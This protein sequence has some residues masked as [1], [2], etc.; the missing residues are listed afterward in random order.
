MVKSK[1]VEG[2]RMK[3][4]TIIK[5]LSGCIFVAVLLLAMVLKYNYDHRQVLITMASEEIDNSEGILAIRTENSNSPGTYVTSNYKDL[6]YSTH[7]FDAN[8]SY[9]VRGGTVV[10]DKTNPS[11]PV[12]KV[13]ARGNDKCFAYFS[14]LSRAPLGMR[15][16]LDNGGEATILAKNPPDFSTPVP[17]VSYVDTI[18]SAETNSAFA[19]ST[20][21]NKYVT[22]STVAPTFDTVTGKYSFGSGDVQTA[23][24]ETFVDNYRG[25]ISSPVYLV[26]LTPSDTNTL[27]TYTNLNNA[28]RI[29]RISGTSTFNIRHEDHEGVAGTS[30]GASGMYA[31]LDDYGTSYYFRGAVANNYVDFANY[32]WRIIRVN[33]DGTVKIIL[34]NAADGSV[35]A[36]NSV[37]PYN[38][39]RVGYVYT[40]GQSHGTTTGSSAKGMLEEWY[41]GNIGGGYR[42]YLADT[43][44]CNDR[45]VSEGVATGI[46]EATF[47][48]YNRVTGVNAP[49]LICPHTGDLLSK[50]DGHL[51]R[52]VGMITADELIMGGLIASSTTWQ[53]AT[54]NNY[55]DLGNPYWTMTPSTSGGSSS[56]DMVYMITSDSVQVPVSNTTYYRVPV[57]NIK[58]DV[59]A[60]GSGTSA[61]PY[62]ID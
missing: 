42:D 57:V 53:V 38:N 39:E 56:S 60:S 6:S 46:A 33:G 9:C 27:A 17:L 37:T 28:Y 58:A 15:V 34:D 14:L 19:Y 36:Y 1:R 2:N 52:N 48:G 43:K 24:M 41:L 26:S 30:G 21:W 50:A 47:N 7:F 45:S 23:Q 32:T 13:H 55:L 12:L 20:Y 51:G 11:S 8:K 10:I 18:I 3:R 61:N 22:Y 44:F 25:T 35:G 40:I 62:L 16:V 59:Y 31:A 5:L 4:K 29:T 49:T 54:S